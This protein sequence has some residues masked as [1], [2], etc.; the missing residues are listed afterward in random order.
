MSFDVVTVLINYNGSDDTLACLQSLRKS[1]QLP[2]VVLVDN[3]S[4]LGSRVSTDVAKEAYPN[5]HV[6]QSEENLGFGGG[7][8]LGISWALEHTD[9][10]YVYILNNDTIS[11][12]NSI[13]ILTEYMKAHP[14]VGAC[15]P[16]IM[17]LDYP[18]TVWYG[19]GYLDWSK[20][21]ARSPMINKIFD[22]CMDNSNVTFITG[23]AMFLRREVL[24]ETKGFDE[25]FFIY[26]EDVDLSA[27]IIEAGYKI[28]YIPRSLLLHKAHS[29]LREGEGEH[30]FTHS[31]KNPRLTFFLEHLVYGSLLN[32]TLH[33]TYLERL[34]GRLRLLIRWLKWSVSYM[35]NGRFDAFRAMWR[36]WTRFYKQ[37]KQV[38]YQK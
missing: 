26:C 13:S 32:L 11:T 4:E 7:N 29:S 35:L 16:R 9:C 33:A 36:G 20:G 6:I 34:Q 14:E 30:F 21:G 12:H 37:K 24:E 31:I 28:S 38:M 18:D 19:G 27:R 17:S 15:S 2:F 5:I 8:N 25:R 3:G 1:D 22:G 10:K 23:C